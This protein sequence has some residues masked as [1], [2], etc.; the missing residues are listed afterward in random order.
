ML[1]V[2]L[3]CVNNCFKGRKGFLYHIV[4]GKE[5]WIHYNNPKHRRLRDKPGHASALAA[6]LNIQGPKLPLCIWWDQLGV[7]YC[8]LLKL[9]KT[10][11][12]DCYQL[13]LR[14]LSWALKK[15]WPLYEQRHDKVILEHDNARLHV[16][17]KW[18]PTWKCLNGKSYSSCHIHQII[19]CSDQWHMV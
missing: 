10:I 19:T 13:Q 14:G 7:V 18:K 15:K 9:T 17:N 5:K 3:S 2:I 1:N 8:E 11:T 6:K 12:G 4:T 16:E